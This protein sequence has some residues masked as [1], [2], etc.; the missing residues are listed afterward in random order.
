MKDIK[1][2]KLPSIEETVN[3]FKAPTDLGT[4]IKIAFIRKRVFH[5]AKLSPHPHVEFAFGFLITKPVP[6]NPSS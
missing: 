6:I 3:S 1:D 5:I 4:N 2:F